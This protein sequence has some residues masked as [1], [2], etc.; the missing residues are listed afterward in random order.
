MNVQKEIKEAKKE[1]ARLKRAGWKQKDFAK[2]LK[3]SLLTQV[4][5]QPKL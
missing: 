2:A 5:I 3:S 4:S 1:M